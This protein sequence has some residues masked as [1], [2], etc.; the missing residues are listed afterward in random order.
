M[1]I[2]ESDVEKWLNDY[3]FGFTRVN[4]EN[5][6]D[7]IKKLA[8]RSVSGVVLYSDEISE[9]YVNLASSIG[10]LSNAIPLTAEAYDKWKANGIELPVIVDIRG[11]T[12]D[13]PTEIYKY[14]FDNYWDDCNKRILLVQGPGFAV[15]MRDLASAVGGAVVYLSSAGGTETKMFKE[16]LMDMK[17]GKSILTGWYGGQ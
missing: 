6:F 2:L 14:F 17:P 10:N 7:S 4:S 11:I 9:H 5:V 16:Y 12:Y 15:Q 13:N 3:G 1:V 8:E